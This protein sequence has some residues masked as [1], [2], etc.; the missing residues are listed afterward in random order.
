[1][2]AWPSSNNI[3]YNSNCDKSFNM[4]PQTDQIGCAGAFDTLKDV[5]AKIKVDCES[6]IPISRC[7]LSTVNINM[8]CTHISATQRSLSKTEE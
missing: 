5:S 8:L 6:F 2:S 4:L 7:Q 1:M 3:S